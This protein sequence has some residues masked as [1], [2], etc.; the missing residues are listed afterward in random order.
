MFK[1][2]KLLSG[3]LMLGAA[4]PAASDELRV[5]VS[6]E[7]NAS[8]KSNS[9]NSS[10]TSSTLKKV[11]GNICLNTLDGEREICVPNPSKK[12]LSKVS[13]NSLPYLPIN[14][15]AEFSTFTVDADS[16]KQVKDTLDSTGWYATVEQDIMVHS[17]ELPNDE[18]LFN[19]YYLDDP[20]NSNRDSKGAHNFFPFL[21]VEQLTQQETIG[22][23]II[24]SGFHDVGEELI[25]RGGATFSRTGPL[26]RGNEYL[27]TVEDDCGEHGLG[28]ASVVGA[29]PNNGIAYTG[30]GGNVNI[31]AAVALNCGYGGLYAAAESLRWFAG[32]SF[33]SEGIADFNGEV[34]VVNLSLGAGDYENGLMCPSFMQS[35]IDFARSKGISVV[36]SAGNDGNDV[37]KHTPSNCE[38]VI[39]AGANNR[40]GYRS[41]FS[42]YGEEVDI[43]AGGEM[44][45]ALDPDINREIAYDGT[46]FSAPLV[47]SALTHAYRI[48]PDMTPS[49]AELVLKLS[50]RK[51]EDPTCEKLKCGAGILDVQN[52]VDLVSA[53]S[54][55]TSNRISWALNDES[56]CDQQ[57]YVDSFGKKG[58]MC[59]ML[60][61]SFFN[62]PTAQSVKYRMY[63]KDLMNPSAPEELVIETSENT[64][65]LSKD[66]IDIGNYDYSVVMCTDESCSSESIR[67]ELETKDAFIT[68][69][70]AVCQN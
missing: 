22:V 52:M 29:T 2:A 13:S 6:Y 20:E 7:N 66:D 51:F 55:D 41:L 42:N 39:V 24:D 53:L 62:L 47:A 63:A 46:S 35:A 3:F 21:S 26:A 57:W 31:Y 68:E 30:A 34:K 36:V 17:N 1:K 58:K 18:W 4:L 45:A 5:I 19:Q 10:A 12:S 43:S 44:V 9:F 8:V 61:A 11:S 69:Q 32:E 27:V 60:K 33:S 40:T 16:F 70:P 54:S 15:A 23:G 25:Y 59:S 56:E 28:V 50:A 49:E 14:K 37:R 38:G 48:N 64:V 65:L 67:F